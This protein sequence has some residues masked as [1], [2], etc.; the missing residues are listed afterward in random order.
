M[1]FVSTRSIEPLKLTAEVSFD[2]ADLE[3]VTDPGLFYAI[4]SGKWAPSKI[5]SKLELMLRIALL[6]EAA[7]AT[8][9]NERIT[10]EPKGTPS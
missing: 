1:Q 3:A 6:S 8:T 2:A 9:L 7:Q 5:S 10:L 4:F